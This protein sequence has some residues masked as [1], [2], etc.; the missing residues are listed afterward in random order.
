MDAEAF[1]NI[2]NTLVTATI[3]IFAVGLGLFGYSSLKEKLAAR[4]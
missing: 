3:V 1:S 4:R 2:L